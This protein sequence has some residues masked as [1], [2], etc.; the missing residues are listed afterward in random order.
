MEKTEEMAPNTP[1][2]GL[3]NDISDNPSELDLLDAFRAKRDSTKPAKDKPTDTE[4]TTEE[5]VKDKPEEPRKYSFDQ[6]AEKLGLSRDDFI[7]NLYDG[8]GESLTNLKEILDGNLRQSEFTKKTQALAESRKAFEADRDAKIAELD[9]QAQSLASH[10]NMAEQMLLQEY[11]TVDWGKLAADDP[12]RAALLQNQFNQRKH[13]ID[14]IAANA[15]AEWEARKKE[16]ADRQAKQLAD[17]QTKESEKLKEAI[18]EWIDPAVQTKELQNIVS[19]LGKMLSKDEISGIAD[20]RV[21]LLARKAMMFDA[22]GKDSVA[23]KVKEK[24]I[25]S[26]PG[27]QQSHAPINL[28]Q[29]AKDG[30]SEVDLLRAF[31]KNRG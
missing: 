29:M 31:R 7:T 20:H 17:L 2:K 5:I 26:K 22:L 30:A 25:A 3:D 1:E 19:Y 8:K 15:A 4:Q 14:Q 28:R 11:N 13:E 24:A 9:S 21:F 27:K 16:A 6:V 12:G 23:K 18:P 10:L